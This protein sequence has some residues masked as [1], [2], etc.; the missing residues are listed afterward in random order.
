M[1]SLTLSTC[2][3]LCAMVPAVAAEQPAL[4]VEMLDVA[5]GDD[6]TGQLTYLNYQAP[7]EL[8]LI[9]I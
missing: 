6:W 2:L 1:K 9:H 4:T 8:S 5:V 7:F 3:A